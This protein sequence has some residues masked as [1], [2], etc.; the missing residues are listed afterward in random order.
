MTEQKT[1]VGDDADLGSDL[2]SPEGVE[3]V[4]VEYSKE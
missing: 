1:A 2:V 4:F 3:N